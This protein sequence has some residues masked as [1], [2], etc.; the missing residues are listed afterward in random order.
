MD[1]S[2]QCG[3]LHAKLERNRLL[4]SCWFASILVLQSM[5]T[6]KEGQDAAK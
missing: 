1:L 5:Q 2:E 6:A 4:S 3:G